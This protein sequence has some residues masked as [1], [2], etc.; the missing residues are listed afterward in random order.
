MAPWTKRL[1]YDTCG[2]GNLPLMR[3][4]SDGRAERCLAIVHQRYAYLGPIVRNARAGENDDADG[5]LGKQQI[6]ALE[7]SS[8]GVG[9]S[10]GPEL[11][12]DNLVGLS[13]AGGDAL[14]AFG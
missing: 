9:G 3:L 14:C 11:D 7:W 8:L 6:V 4:P 2:K 1:R 13:P 12:L 10:A 5:E